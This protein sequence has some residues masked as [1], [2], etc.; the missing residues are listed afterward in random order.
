METAIEPVDT[1]TVQETAR[2]IGKHDG[3]VRQG[4]ITG[5]LPFGSAVKQDGAMK[6]DFNIVTCSHH[7]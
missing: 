6:W 1:L 4:L 3:Y 7:L 5:R 2:I